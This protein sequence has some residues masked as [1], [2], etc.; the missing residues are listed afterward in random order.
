MGDAP[1]LRADGLHGP[2]RPKSLTGAVR[3]RISNQLA[4][5]NFG[6]IS[7]RETAAPRVLELDGLRGLACLTILAYHIRP[8]AVPYGWTSVDLFFVLSGYL[9]TAIL[10]RHRGSPGLLKSFYARRGLRI[11]PIYYLTIVVLVILGPWL[12]RPTSW[13]GLGYYLTYTQNIPRYW[14]GRV[15]AFSPYLNHFWTLANE[16]QFYIVW[17]ILVITLGRRP[18]PAHSGGG[19][20]L[21]RGSGPRT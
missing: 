3:R 16:E 21:G 8:A 5:A 4:R 7:A 9:I 6:A 17:P 20:D 11:W 19:G 15:P 18:D 10:V 1:F 14:S 2:D 13:N 12:P